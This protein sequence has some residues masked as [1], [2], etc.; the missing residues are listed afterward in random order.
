M[1]CS[2]SP[3]PRRSIKDRYRSS[4]PGDNVASPCASRN[5]RS[6]LIACIASRLASFR[7]SATPAALSFA[8]PVE[9]AFLIVALML[10][11]DSY[12]LATIACPAD[13]ILGLTA[14]LNWK[15]ASEA[16][17]GG[18]IDCP[19]PSCSQEHGWD[20]SFTLSSTKRV[21]FLPV[22]TAKPPGRTLG[23]F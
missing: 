5:V 23:G 7:G 19:L 13:S 3:E 18:Q 9:M 21:S 14:N 1:Y 4:W 8:A 20:L 22:R 2:G 16:F 6:R 17:L 10:G 15:W 12:S 11:F